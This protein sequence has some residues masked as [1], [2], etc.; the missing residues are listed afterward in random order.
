[1]LRQFVEN[2]D[3]LLHRK[4]K[5]TK[6]YTQSPIRPAESAFCNVECNRPKLNDENLQYRGCDQDSAEQ[7]ISEDASEHIDCR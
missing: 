5:E 6:T 2:I 7:G 1:M 4:G 3:N